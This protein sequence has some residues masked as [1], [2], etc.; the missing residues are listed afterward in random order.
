MKGVN[1]TDKIEVSNIME[2]A[3]AVCNITK[4]DIRSKSRKRE[5]QIPRT[6]I[7]NIARIEKNIH[8]SI[9]SDVINRDRC[10]IIHYE[11]THRQNFENWKIYRNYF[12]KIFNAYTDIKYNKRKFLDNQALKSFL[13][14]N[15]VEEVL[16]PNVFI[17]IKCGE[18]FL[19][20]KTNYRYFSNQ[21]ELIRLALTNENYEYS[22]TV[23]LK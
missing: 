8:H 23:N 14:N 15:S 7:S 6:V 9:I 16:N 10:S 2:I 5:Y 3:C 1:I 11:N 12:N 19:T 21:L 18:A 20:I 4:E 17:D 22:L 13:Y